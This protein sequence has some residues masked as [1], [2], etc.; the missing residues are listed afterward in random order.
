MQNNPYAAPSAEQIASWPGYLYFVCERERVRM[1]KESGAPAPWTHDPILQKY[2]FTCVRRKDDRMSKW[3]IKHLIEPYTNRTDLW[4]TLLVAR[5]INWPPMIQR[6]IE[7]GVL[8][9]SPHEFDAS[10]FVATVENY[11]DG[12]NK[13]YGDA[14]LVY[15]TRMDPGGNKSESLAKWIIGD[16]IKNHKAVHHSLWDADMGQ[17][18]VAR[19]VTE[20][21]EC[22]GISTFTA[23]QVA[24]DLATDLGHLGNAEDLLTWAP[25]GPG[26]QAGLNYLFGKPV[27]AKWDQTDF[28]HALMDARE[29]VVEELGIEDVT[30]HDLQ[31]CTCEYGKYAR[32]VLATGK[33]KSLYK[34]QKAY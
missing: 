34:P 5:L 9:C 20:L 10:R 29:R 15:P 3:F 8:P 22:F 31:N 4:F 1:L 18:S 23:G 25:L 27:S 21:S 2:K 28:N 11:K 30:L 24:A 7:Q 12:G 32:T 26:S 17:P 14:Y 13:V 33:P 16:V 6:L 19:F